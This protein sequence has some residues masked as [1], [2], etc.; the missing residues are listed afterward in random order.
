MEYRCEATSVAGFI[1]RLA[2]DCIARGYHRYVI[3]DIPAKKD[4]RLID[5]K[6]IEK[7]SLVDKSAR[8][9]RKLLGLGNVQCIRY[10]RFFI[11]L[12]SSYG[13]HEI[14]EQ[15]G[16]VIQDVA[17]MPIK[18]KGHS[19]S[20]S[21]GHVRVQ[22]S[23]DLYLRLKHSFVNNALR[24]S[25]AE[26]TVAFR[27]LRFEAYAPVRSQLLCILRAVNCRRKVAGLELLPSSRLRLYR[28]YPIKPRLCLPSPTE[29]T[30]VPSVRSSPALILPRNLDTQ[31]AYKR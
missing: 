16:E 11:L 19:I 13:Y 8:H 6:M 5:R 22:I 10:Q 9:R 2:V 30:I 20:F 26:L 21:G 12:V 7:F 18:F 17:R 14:F 28:C 24:R 31:V 4:P 3:A 29:E 27:A 25:A 15:E 23:H 1:Q